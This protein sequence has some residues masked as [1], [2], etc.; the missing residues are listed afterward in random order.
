MDQF[1]IE[2]IFYQYFQSHSYIESDRTVL[3][4]YDP[5]KDCVFKN[6]SNEDWYQIF[7]DIDEET[8]N[9]W[10]YYIDRVI[11]VALEKTN[12][13]PFGVICIQE[14]HITPLLVCFHGGV[15]EH[16]VKN[17][18]LEYEATDNILHFLVNNGF[19]VF[20][21]CFKDNK[22]ADRFQKSLGFEEFQQDETLSYKSL[23][24]DKLNTNIISLRKNNKIR[25]DCLKALRDSIT[26]Q[27][28]LGSK[29]LFHS[30]FL[31]WLSIIDWD[32]FLKVL[33]KLAGIG[34]NDSFWWEKENCPI[35]VEGVTDR[36]FR[37][38]NG[39]IIVR[40]EY[41]HYD[42]SIYILYGYTNPRQDG[43]PK[44]KWRPVLILENKVKSMPYQEQLG[45]YAQKAFSEWE[46]SYPKKQPKDSWEKKGV[47]FVLLTLFDE[48]TF[49][50]TKVGPNGQC[51]HD[52]TWHKS[53]YHTLSTA[54]S[55]AFKRLSSNP[56]AQTIID[57]YSLFAK[58]LHNLS[59]T[60][61]WLVKEMDSYQD[62][63]IKTAP[64]E[65]RLRIADILEKVHHERMLRI[66]IDKLEQSESLKSKHE[67]WN[68]EKEFK[69]PKG[70]KNYNT[71]IV[72]YETAF[73][74][75]KGATQ[76]FVIVNDDYRLM[77]QLQN[78]QYRR[79]V[80]LH[81]IKKNIDKKMKRICD[82][83]NKIWS[84]YARSKSF[85]KFFNYQYDPITNETV[86]DILDKVVSDLE[87]IFSNIVHLKNLR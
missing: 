27:M 84:G 3:R 75:G 30:N 53:N 66:L 6:F 40:R 33:H 35:E 74:R 52:I 18:L 49:I 8:F 13:Q 39:N 5:D 47:T 41:N 51:K 77:I 16:N 32:C 7:P 73:S 70:E 14:S 81:P 31:E 43:I 63:I 65:T 36:L 76:V 82:G 17:M 57:D 60:E 58:T 38:E 83:L 67:H 72:F 78:N 68:K 80:I 11:L 50:Q 2:D 37:P 1:N 44:P 54:I 10:T 12:D 24:I 20:V 48:A 9:Q 46:Q 4:V 86:N 55:D 25:K 15:W 85:G 69:G 19:E 45:Q 71:G 64:E 87:A 34:E 59:K 21:T 56:K 23:N 28:S 79:C 62:K 29:E 42:L 22:K 26:F 61:S